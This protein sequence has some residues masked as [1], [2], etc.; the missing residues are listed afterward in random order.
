MDERTLFPTTPAA[1]PI[2]PIRCLG[3]TFPDDN[4]RREHF[5]GVLR[6]KLKDPELRK[7]EGFPIG[8][9]ED[10]LATSDP[11]YY[12]AC[13]NPFLADLVREWSKSPSPS[14]GEGRGEGGGQPYSRNPLAIDV[15]EGKTDPLY[16]AHSYHTKVPHKAI[17]PAILHYTD[18]G[19]IVLDGFCGSGMTGVAAQVCAHPNPELKQSLEQARAAAG[20]PPRFFA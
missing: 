18:P 17:A 8:S 10:I 11:P 6:E 13:P 9:D 7:I 19:D 4:A 2:G 3:Q 15:S 1:T 16:K 12:T 20:L 14:M 5:L